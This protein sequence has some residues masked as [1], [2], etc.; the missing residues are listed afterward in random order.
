MSDTR[1]IKKKDDAAERLAMLFREYYRSYEDGDE[2]WQI[3]KNYY[4]DIPLELV[5]IFEKL[6]GEMNFREYSNLGQETVSTFSP[7]FLSMLNWTPS[8]NLI[9][10]I[11]L[12]EST[13][14]TKYSDLINPPEIESYLIQI[15]LHKKNSPSV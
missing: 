6:K 8:D 15:E 1:K 12:I 3:I 14:E 4:A 11:H 13:A 7:L 10:V 9:N 2:P 5:E